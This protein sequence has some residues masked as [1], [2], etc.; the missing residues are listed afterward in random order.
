MATFS[1]VLVANRGEIAI[2]IFRTLRDLGVDSVAVYSDP[3]RNAQHPR[4]A[5]EAFALGGDTSAESYLVV[6]KLLAAAERSGAD[7]VHP[8][9][10]FLSENAAFARAVEAAGLTFIGPTPDVLEQLG[11]KVRARAL[12]EDC[13]VPVLS[14]AGPSD[15]ASASAFLAALPAGA[16]LMVKAVSGGGGR[17][18]R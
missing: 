1:K 5:D 10:G 14:G 8:G 2:R 12:A 9:Y 17:G 11:D 3:D 15:L 4:Y 18:M 13:G 6:E 7:A 16:A